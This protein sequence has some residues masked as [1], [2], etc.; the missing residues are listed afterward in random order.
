M[1]GHSYSVMP[2]VR[3]TGA[4]GQRQTLGCV[5]IANARLIQDAATNQNVLKRVQCGTRS[6]HKHGNCGSVLMLCILVIAIR[7][8]KIVKWERLSQWRSVQSECRDGE[9]A[10]TFDCG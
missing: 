8:K 9:A 1:D 2:P 3:T 10:T 5:W 7:P 6:L 4:I